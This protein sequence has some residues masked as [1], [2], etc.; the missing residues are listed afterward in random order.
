M[1]KLGIVSPCYNEEDVLP[2][3]VSKFERLFDDLKSRRIIAD[4]SFVMFVN[5]GSQDKTWEL[6][7]RF[8]EE[9]KFIFG[10]NLTHNVGHQN[11]IMAGMMTAYPLCDALI[12]IDAD[13]QDD[14]NC[15]EQMIALCEQGNDIV[16][17][18]KKSRKKD[19]FM[20]RTTA[21]AF[22]KLQE[23]MGVKAVFNHADFRLMKKEA[24]E[25]LAQYH[26]KN[27]YLRGLMPTI[28][29]KTAT[30]NDTISERE[31]GKSKYTLR[32]MLHLAADGIFSFSTTPIK[33]IFGAGFLFMFA[34]IVTMV[35]I[36]VSL[37]SG[38][39]VQGWAS[40]M[41]SLWLIGGFIML[42]LGI[43]GEYIG[44]IYIEVK[45]RP[46]YHVQE[47]LIK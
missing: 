46:L 10:V 1:I 35:Y 40:L 11:A 3:S 41:A 38:H 12:T 4:D 37:V 15:I 42:A 9:K 29:H 18:V 39:V 34:F 20:K 17:G 36:I 47:K 30:V 8:H 5:D 45:D 7:S 43:I 16:Y 26:E 27:L 19:S 2:L 44:K 6:I 25:R 13:V 23:M 21:V 31:A 32:K 33:Y 28:G 22:Y 24:V 14:L